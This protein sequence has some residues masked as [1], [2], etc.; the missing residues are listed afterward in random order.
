MTKDEFTLAVKERNLSKDQATK[1]YNSYIAKYKAFD[2]EI[3]SLASIDGIRASKTEPERTWIDNSGEADEWYSKEAITQFMQKNLGVKTSLE[4]AMAGRKIYNNNNL[5][6]KEIYQKLSED[7]RSGEISNRLKSVKYS[8]YG[9][10]GKT[11]KEVREFL[12]SGPVEAL[13]YATEYPSKGYLKAASRL[14]VGTAELVLPKNLEK[15]LGVEKAREEI[16][17]LDEYQREIIDQSLI[18]GDYDT[19]VGHTIGLVVGDTIGNLLLMKQGIGLAN[20]L[21][22]GS[23][24]LSAK[25][26]T[27]AKVS[28]NVALRSSV[29]S[30]MTFL[31]TEGSVKERLEAASLQFAYMNTPVLSSLAKT[32]A[33]AKALDFALNSLISATYKKGEGFVKYGQYAG[34]KAEAKRMADELGDPDA[35]FPILI[36]QVIPV[37]GSDAVFS[38]LSKSVRAQQRAGGV[39][40]QEASV[41]LFRAGSDVALEKIKS[42]M[43]DKYGADWIGKMDDFDRVEYENARKIN[44]DLAQGILP[45]ALEEISKP[46]VRIDMGRIG[47]VVN[48]DPIERTW[49]DNDGRLVTEITS[50]PEMDKIDLAEKP[51]VDDSRVPEIVLFESNAGLLPAPKPVPFSDAMK[52]ALSDLEK[53]M[54]SDKLTEVIKT[55]ADI[56]TGQIPEQIRLGQKASV[57]LMSPDLKSKDPGPWVEKQITYISRLMAMGQIKNKTDYAEVLD[58]YTQRGDVDPDMIYDQA[59][60]ANVNLEETM[61]DFERLSKK[62]KITQKQFKQDKQMV[63]IDS[64]QIIKDR[65]RAMEDAAKAGKR[66]GIEQE[67]IRQNIRRERDILKIKESK[68]EQVEKAKA[69]IKELQEQNKESIRKI[70]DQHAQRKA[71]L[72][73]IVSAGKEIV[74]SIAPN[75]AIKNRLLIKAQNIKTDKALNKFFIDVTNFVGDY[76][77]NKERN[78]L[79]DN[80]LKDPTRFTSID[81]N[82]KKTTGDVA[83][84]YVESVQDIQDMINTDTSVKS[85]WRLQQQRD[86]LERNP[87]LELPKKVLEKLQQTRI[88][89]ISIEELRMINDE[90]QRLKQVGMTLQKQRQRVFKKD[91]E[92]TVSKIRS[93]A[94]NKVDAREVV[95]NEK[96]KRKFKGLRY[97]FGVGALRPWNL[98]DLMDGGKARYDGT[99]FDLFINKANDRYSDYLVM[100]DARI[101]GGER[102]IR[103]NKL[104]VKDLVRK[105]DVPGMKD[106][107]TLDELLSVYGSSKNRLMH[108]AVLHGNFKGNEK[109]YWAAVEMVESQPKWK[110]LAD[111]IVYDYNNNYGRVRKA[112]I[113]NENRILGNEENYIPMERME[114]EQKSSATITRSEDGEISIYKD[115]SDGMSAREDAKRTLPG[116]NFTIDRVEIKDSEQKPVR[117]GLFEQWE[118]TVGNQERYINMYEQVKK[119]SNVINDNE[120]R[121]QLRR[122]YGNDYIEAVDGYIDSYGNPM[123][124]YDV[125]TMARGSRALRKNFASGV[126]SYNFLT[127][128]KQV[129]SMLLYMGQGGGRNMLTAIDD[130]NTSWEIRDGK[131]FNK[132]VE[133]VESKDPQVKHAHIERELAELKSTNRTKYEQIVGKIGDTGMKGII[134]LDKMVRTIGWYST[135]M[136]G[137]ET[138][139]SEAE[140]IQM[141]RNATNR[142]QPAASAKDLPDMYKKDEF[143]NWFLMFSNQINQIYNIASYQLPRKFVDGNPGEALA[144][145]SGLVLNALAIHILTHKD[146]PDTD[147]EIKQM[148]LENTAGKTPLYGSIITSGINGY[149]S[150]NPVV[151][152]LSGSAQD[153][154]KAMESG[155]EEAYQKALKTI[156]VNAGTATGVPINGPRR[157]LKA[158]NSGDPM[159]LFGKKKEK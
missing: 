104:R 92:D 33:G 19:F 136:R 107:L 112:F 78:G 117:L 4:A 57:E 151:S 83:A 8:Q 67:K 9:I 21:L 26:K 28:K 10:T 131:P 89:D 109:S 156:V 132:L 127:M 155:D 3:P 86:A 139:K 48:D 17:H 12:D 82:G 103:E 87:N 6:N 150:E 74:R 133:F 73:D 125:S 143:A 101:S 134:A 153:A 15:K 147:E 52:G 35:Y 157:I 119:M 108:N 81:L 111:Y 47:R 120:L 7:I 75:E 66:L 30:G 142:T 76:V 38:M 69:R 5:S 102:F 1:A 25:G 152:L 49:R 65:M 99:A 128:A 13:R 135:Y 42:T 149:D 71:D 106:K 137:M 94:K 11:E 105:H 77:V 159:E 54:S 93:T 58:S 50:K 97:L 115:F 116:N 59:K 158:A 118:R 18:D 43:A 88:E 16:N 41:E 32:D 64:M 145:T 72:D 46:T 45:P 70:R 24:T 113:R 114:I 95:A 37:A 62:A 36:S 68:A 39:S 146:L 126:L 53:V 130:F 124:L 29:I 110:A 79:R 20:K 34:M 100:N 96:D 90:V 84:E 56:G 121:K 27:W 91:V 138:G 80:I 51:V 60:R 123:S 40:A 14:L 144:I 122:S 55:D 154:W 98:V 141:A 31:S 148:I 85:A 140:A 61:K 44:A 63:L 22:G 23:L 2:D 129:P